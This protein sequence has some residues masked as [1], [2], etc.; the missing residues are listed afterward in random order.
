[1]YRSRTRE[2]C[3]SYFSSSS[4]F[5]SFFPLFL[6]APEDGRDKLEIRSCQMKLV[7]QPSRPSALGPIKPYIPRQYLLFFWND[8]LAFFLFFFMQIIECCPLFSC[9]TTHE[10]RLELRVQVRMDE[11]PS[12]TNFKARVFFG[13]ALFYIYHLFLFPA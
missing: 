8:L 9:Y 3:L 4:S 12:T 13:F 2:V 10:L 7:S 11:F 5:F 6:F 1:M